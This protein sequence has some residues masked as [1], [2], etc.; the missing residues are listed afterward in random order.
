MSVEIKEISETANIQN[1]E[2]FRE[3]AEKVLYQFE[4]ET[5]ADYPKTVT[6]SVAWN[7]KTDTGREADQ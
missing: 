4:E 1:A 6:I 7:D 3:W 5:D 2:A